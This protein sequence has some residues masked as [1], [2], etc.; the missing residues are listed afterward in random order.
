MFC[1]GH[2][3]FVAVLKK[4]SYDVHETFVHFSFESLQSLEREEY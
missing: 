3:S 2:S 4:K 1:V